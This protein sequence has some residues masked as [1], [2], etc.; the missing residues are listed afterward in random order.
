MN[1]TK[2]TGCGQKWVHKRDVNSM[3]SPMEYLLKEK[4]YDHFVKLTLG[5]FF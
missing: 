2:I 5:F 4:S 1:Q 3:K